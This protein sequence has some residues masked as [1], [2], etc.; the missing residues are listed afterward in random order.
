MN[1]GHPI[2]SMPFATNYAT[3][4]NS[5]MA[6]TPGHQQTP[7]G[8]N[9]TPSAALP[10]LT[11]RSATQFIPYS[12]TPTFSVNQNQTPRLMKTPR[13]PLI[14]P[15]YIPR[16]IFPT[17]A[18]T[19]I[20]SGNNIP[21]RYSTYSS[22]LREGGSSLIVS[23]TLGRRVL[24]EKDEDSEEEE[25]GSFSSSASK[26]WS[27][28]RIHKRHMS[29]STDQLEAVAQ[30]EETLVPIRL[31]LDI[32]HQYKLRDVF[33][34]NLNESL[35]TPEKFAE[36]LCDELD[37]SVSAHGSNIVNSIK[38]QIQHFETVLDLDI[39]S[40]DARVVINLDL[41]VGQTHLKDQFEWD[42]YSDLSPTTFARQLTSDLALG[43]EFVSLI[44]F[45]IQEQ[46][47]RHRQERVSYADEME[48]S[49]MAP[50]LTSAFRPIEDAEN[51]APKLE[52]LSVEELERILIDNERS[53][54]RLRRDA[55]RFVIN[56]PTEIKMTSRTSSPMPKA[57]PRL[58]E[59]KTSRLPVE[60]LETWRCLHCGI[61]GRNTPLVRRGPDGS[62]TLCNACGLAWQTR[63]KLPEHRL[64]MYRTS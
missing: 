56:R 51:W 5:P 40:E 33:L 64:N 49:D 38:A 36:I 9:S 55:S 22:R 17:S 44:A 59:Y 25:L 2:Q 27:R 13:A 28:R 62:K 19:T 3:F 34:W 29:Y 7:V 46:I 1:N 16:T 42:L 39:P 14:T 43:G 20:S 48:D 30:A 4:I 15:G 61:E 53:I 57:K 63:G 52:I 11:P 35:L 18:P 50:P 58:S 10:N 47:Y 6:S 37:I 12:I 60:E 24:R 26:V 21:G 45:A 32:D 23:G 41:H 31:D 54:R 8:M